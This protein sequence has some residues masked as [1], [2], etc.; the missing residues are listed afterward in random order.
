MKHFL[1]FVLVFSISFSELFA[2][3]GSKRVLLSEIKKWDEARLL[4]LK[5][6]TGWVNLAGLFWLKPGENKFGQGSDNDL[7]F[8]HPEFPVVLGKF[9]L[10][11]H[12]VI[13]ETAV[14]H[15]VSDKGKPVNSVVQFSVDSMQGI[16]LA[17]KTFRWSIIKRENLVGVRFR[18]LANPALDKLQ[19]IPR[20]KVSTDWVIPASFEPSLV[21]TITTTNI[22]GQSYQQPH[23]G[24]I[25]FQVEG[26][27]Y[28]L[29]VV[30][31]GTPGEYHIVFGDETNGDETYASG[32]FIDIHKPDASGMTYI[33]FNKSYNPPCAF[34]EFSTCPIPTKANTL[35]IKIQSG[36]KKVH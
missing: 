20:Y 6:A 8:D 5:S 30:D 36:E 17:Y 32:R 28:S 11:D 31:E 9:I 34:S 15:P 10:N 18:D 12:E 2:Q 29:D 24:K 21:P 13:W 25:H 1:A 23:P 33:N 14:N 27:S 16:S 7:V 26:K 3:H 19:E 22:L 35:P 4:A